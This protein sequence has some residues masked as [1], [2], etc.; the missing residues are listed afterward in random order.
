MKTLPLIVA[1]LLVSIEH[2]AQNVLLSENFTTYEATAGTAPAGWFFSSHASYTSTTNSGPSGPNSYKFGATNT[3]VITAEFPEIA[4]SVIFWIKG[5]STDSLSSFLI[6][7][8]NK[9]AL[10]WD[11]LT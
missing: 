5:V 9:S 2:R 7:Q 10:T 3:E 8:Y 1:C 11:T 6:E 4:D